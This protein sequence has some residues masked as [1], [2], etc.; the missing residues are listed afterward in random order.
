MVGV[1]HP[2]RAPTRLTMLRIEYT[3]NAYTVTCETC[4]DPVTGEYPY[5]IG[6]WKHRADPGQWNADHLPSAARTKAWAAFRKHNDK[7]LYPNGGS[8]QRKEFVAKAVARQQPLSASGR[9]ALGRLFGEPVP[10][11][12]NDPAPF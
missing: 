7:H 5:V 8:R 1:S 11:D 12:P 6:V 3:D 9:R 4:S 2:Y 10:P